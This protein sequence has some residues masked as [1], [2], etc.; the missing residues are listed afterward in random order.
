MH[1]RPIMS[2]PESDD[3]PLRLRLARH[4]VFAWMGLRPVFA[5]HTLSE[6]EALR[7]WAAGR[8]HL[9]EIGVA[10][11]AS[12]G[13]LAEAMAPM[14]TLT[15]IDPFHLSRWKRIN[16]T[17][18]L[19]HAVV[20]RV[21]RGR[22]VWVEQMSSEAL[23]CWKAQID[24]LFIDGDHHEQTVLQDWTGWCAF[25][26]RGGVVIFHDARVFPGG[27]P[28]PSDG[29][30]RAVNEMFRGPTALP[31]WQIV[32]EVHSLVVVQRER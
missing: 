2:T 30:V 5:Q 7:R 8:A 14:G 21:A 22:V 11:G 4:P 13:A 23:R 20:S 16:A 25:V 15:L 18:R 19:A 10:E 17:K 32:D 26:A 1:F 6:H 3:S 31:D 27:W 28:G 24:F 29:P 9:V 12:A